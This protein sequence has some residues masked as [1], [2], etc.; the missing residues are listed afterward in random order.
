ME[1]YLGERDDLHD[2]ALYYFPTKCFSSFFFGEQGTLLSKNQ[3]AAAF[4]I[5]CLELEFPTD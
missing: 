5:Y 1:A 4:F 3:T 2:F